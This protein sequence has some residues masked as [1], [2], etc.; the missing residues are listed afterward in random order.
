LP[1]EVCPPY[2]YFRWGGKTG[3]VREKE[4]GWP[5]LTVETRMQRGTLPREK[6]TSINVERGKKGK[7]GFGPERINSCQKKRTVISK[8]KG[9]RKRRENHDPINLLLAQGTSENAVSTKEA[10]GTHSGL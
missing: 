7:K 2:S 3:F 5:V 9:K 1:G 10:P 8:P 6:L 4:G